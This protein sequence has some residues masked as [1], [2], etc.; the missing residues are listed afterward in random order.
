M[1]VPTHG[2]RTPGHDT[3]AQAAIALLIARPG[4]GILVRAAEEAEVV[5]EGAFPGVDQAAPVVPVQAGL[6]ADC[7]GEGEVALL[8]KMSVVV[9]RGSCGHK[10]LEGGVL[11]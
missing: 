6:G 9:F 4:I 8:A 10:G 5:A 1:R 11:D 2:I 3:L 7:V